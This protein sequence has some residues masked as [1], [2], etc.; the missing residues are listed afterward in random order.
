MRRVEDD[1][2][3]HYAGIVA[4]VERQVFK[5]VAGAVA[6]MRIA[7]LELPSQLPAIGID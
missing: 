2:F 1:G 4:A 3:I 5:L 6:K 7:P